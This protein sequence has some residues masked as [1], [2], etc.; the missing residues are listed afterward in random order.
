MKSLV[1]VVVKMRPQTNV[2]PLKKIGSRNNLQQVASNHAKSKCSQ[3]TQWHQGLDFGAWCVRV[4]ECV[5]CKGPLDRAPFTHPD[6]QRAVKKLHHISS[7]V[8]SDTEKQC[9]HS[10]L[11][12]ALLQ[13]PTVCVY[14]RV[15]ASE[16]MCL[17]TSFSSFYPMRAEMKNK[18]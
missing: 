4:Y 2:F 13:F 12:F 7:Q 1:Y 10:C 8:Y 5:D 16:C 9:F 14:M 18:K 11:T 6:R 17:R 15:S 3:P